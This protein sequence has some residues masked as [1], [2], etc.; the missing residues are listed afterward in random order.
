MA[1]ALGS[2]KRQVGQGNNATDLDSWTGEQ[3]R[4]KDRWDREISSSKIQLEQEN[5]A[6]GK[7]SWPSGLEH[8]SRK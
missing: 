7:V 6:G 1:G 4:K 2:I 3:R 8:Y 5:K